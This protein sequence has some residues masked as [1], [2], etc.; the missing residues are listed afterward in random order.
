ME[1]EEKADDM[2][3]EASGNIDAVVTESGE[4][5]T[6]EK[7]E[8]IK[9]TGNL[10]DF[11]KNEAAEKAI[12]MAIEAT[13]NVEGVIADSRKKEAEE[14]TDGMVIETTGSIGAAELDRRKAEQEDK[15][16]KQ[17]ANLD[18]DGKQ[19]EAKEKT[20][21]L[22]S[23]LDGIKSGPQ[24]FSPKSTPISNK[25]AKKRITPIAIDP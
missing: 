8:M 7:D 24:L 15:T 10:A 16:E 20:E 12:D 4:T 6:Q 13:G 9:S 21:I 14:K 22:Q 1:S 2:V 19:K 11:R 3:I 5:I 17:P 18:S 25:P 23:S